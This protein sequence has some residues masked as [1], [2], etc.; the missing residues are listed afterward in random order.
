MESAET[1]LNQ[2]LILTGIDFSR[3]QLSKL[4]AF[5]IQAGISVAEAAKTLGL[6]EAGWYSSYGVNA[7]SGSVD[8]MIK[9]KLGALL[10]QLA[11]KPEQIYID[12][13]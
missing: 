9:G 8:S 7:P 10:R 11:I 12:T 1:Q 13:E 4:E 2:T 6:T 3:V 5:R